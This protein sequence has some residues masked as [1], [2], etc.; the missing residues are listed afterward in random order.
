M[1]ARARQPVEQF[2]A[3]LAE[4]G[5]TVDRVDTPR[6]VAA[7]V[8]AAAQ[9]AVERIRNGHFDRYGDWRLR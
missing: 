2:A 5:G 7:A 1:H 6:Q 4:T 9:D 3:V 8:A